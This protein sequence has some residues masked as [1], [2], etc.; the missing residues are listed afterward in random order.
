MSRIPGYGRAMGAVVLV[1]FLCTLLSAVYIEAQDGTATGIFVVNGTV[2]R[3]GAP[4]S[5]QLNVEVRNLT[6][7]TPP[8]SDLTGGMEGTGA[9][10]VTLSDLSGN[11]AAAVGDTIE[12]TVYDG[13]GN[14][15]GQITHQVTGD[16]I[17]NS[18]AQINVTLPSSGP[19]DFNS[20]GKVWLEDFIMFVANFGFA[21]GDP[22]FDP[23]FDMNG[24]GLVW[25]EDF[26]EFVKLF[27]T[28]YT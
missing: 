14:V 11:R 25:L 28:V 18:L 1:I 22:G 12:V 7:A 20:D 27:G 9:Y 21:Q 3:G 26:S 8:L 13:G 24:D 6:T 23:M 10:I 17:T 2:Y 15:L 4:V 19:G 16:E 5:E